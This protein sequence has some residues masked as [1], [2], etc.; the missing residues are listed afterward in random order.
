MPNVAYV[1]KTTPGVVFTL[2]RLKTVA[3][4]AGGL[5]TLALQLDWGVE[6]PTWL[7]A[8]STLLTAISVYA[9]PNIESTP[10]RAVLDEDGEPV[11]GEPAQPEPTVSAMRE[12]IHS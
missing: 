9:V 11:Y 12:V 10:K 6:L 2:A 3:A 4:V 5:L 8:L 7:T 1:V